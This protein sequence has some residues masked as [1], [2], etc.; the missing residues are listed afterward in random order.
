V[1]ALHGIVGGNLDDAL[2]LEKHKNIPLKSSSIVLK[3]GRT[4]QLRLAE[5][6]DPA[7]LSEWYCQVINMDDDKKSNISSK[8]H[9]LFADSA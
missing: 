3:Y 5:P 7:W 4:I 2:P 8:L 6:L 9:C 1:H